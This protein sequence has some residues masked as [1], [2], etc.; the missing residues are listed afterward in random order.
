MML[1]PFFL[2]HKVIFH[3]DSKP[4]FGILWQEKICFVILT[5]LSIL[6]KRESDL[7]SSLTLTFGTMPWLLF[8]FRWFF[9]C[10]LS[11][12]NAAKFLIAALSGPAS[13]RTGPIR[14]L[15][16]SDRSEHNLSRSDGQTS[17]LVSDRP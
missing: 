11:H 16:G 15:A 7:K 17:C 9:I 14:Q 4:F 8:A 12:C 10:T 13:C 3:S 6:I 5:S 1:S 2:R